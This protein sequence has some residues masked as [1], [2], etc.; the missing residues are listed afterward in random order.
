MEDTGDVANNIFRQVDQINIADI[1]HQSHGDFGLLGIG[2]VG[3]RV[4]TK[5]LVVRTLQKLAGSV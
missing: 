1:N 4:L 3:N 5:P 2:N